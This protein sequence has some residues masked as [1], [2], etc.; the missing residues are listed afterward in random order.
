M[1]KYIQTLLVLLRFTC[2]AYTGCFK[3]NPND[4]IKNKFYPAN[5]HLK[6]IIS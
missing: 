3:F 5:L 1:Y 2:I 6:A 4:S